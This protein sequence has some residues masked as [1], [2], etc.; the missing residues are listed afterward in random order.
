MRARIEQVLAMGSA[1]CGTLPKLA[2]LEERQGRVR[3][4]ARQVRCNRAAAKAS[5]DDRDV[6]FD[7]RSAGSE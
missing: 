5:A 3:R 2:R 6:E 1:V 7:H 4:E